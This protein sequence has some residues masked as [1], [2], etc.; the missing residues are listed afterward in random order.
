MAEYHSRLQVEGPAAGAPPDPPEALLIEPTAPE[1]IM[2]GWRSASGLLTSPGESVS[3]AVL[4]TPT[5]RHRGEGRWGTPVG[6]SSTPG[7]SALLVASFP[8]TD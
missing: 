5:P 6:A 4:H 3:E 8:T 2:G 7:A 1:G